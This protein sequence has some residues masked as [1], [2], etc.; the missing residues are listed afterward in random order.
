MK[1]ENPDGV[2]GSRIPPLPSGTSRRL[3]LYLEAQ[4]KDYVVLRCHGRIVFG[5]EARALTDIVTDVLPTS[6]RMI[7]DLAGIE[8]VDSAGLGELVMLHMWAEAAG[9]TLKV[10]SPSAS[11]RRLLEL[12]NLLAV[13]DLYGS[14]DEAISAMQHEEVCRA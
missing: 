7:V 13:F 5:P 6:G 9:Y 4:E 12:T 11:V 1:W 3:Q 14:V 8:S 2:L 10:A